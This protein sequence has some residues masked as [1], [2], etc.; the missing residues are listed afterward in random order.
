MRKFWLLAFVAAMLAAIPALTADKSIY[1][2]WSPT[3]N[4]MTKEDLKVSA[5]EFQKAQTEARERNLT[6]SLIGLAGLFG[7]VMLFGF[8]K[9]RRRRMASAAD[10]AIVGSLAAVV[11]A[12]RNLGRKIEERIAAKS[13]DAS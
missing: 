7:A 3:Y 10:A 9:A 1:S 8:I 2:T 6:Y 11:S 4:G 5:I 12:K 13:N